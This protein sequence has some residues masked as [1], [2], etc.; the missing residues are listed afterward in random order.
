MNE[1]SIRTLH[2][3]PSPP[4]LYYE[5][6]FCAQSVAF[7]AD[8]RL[9]VEEAE[10]IP[11]VRLGA[12]QIYDTLP[13]HGRKW[14]IDRLGSLLSVH[15]EGFGLHESKKN[16][17]TLVYCRKMIRWSCGRK[18]SWILICTYYNSIRIFSWLITRRKKRWKTSPG[19][20]WLIESFHHALYGDDRN[21]FIKY[22][23]AYGD[24]SLFINIQE[25]PRWFGI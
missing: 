15:G 21:L 6:V 9:Y 8:R 25:F 11:L 5:Y 22:S 4:T 14:Q 12:A 10:E 16:I 19:G 20:W 18:I 13:C 24:V 3:P 17:F 2:P 1:L 7:I 23:P